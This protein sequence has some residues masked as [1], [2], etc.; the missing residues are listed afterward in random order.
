MVQSTKSDN[1]DT[2]PYGTVIKRPVG[3]P[4]N[5]VITARSLGDRG[6]HYSAAEGDLI[7]HNYPSVFKA[8]QA[9]RISV[10]PEHCYA[11]ELA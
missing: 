1:M 4:N 3:C 11:V 9:L 6:W 8:L 5:I 2:G 7:A 10:P